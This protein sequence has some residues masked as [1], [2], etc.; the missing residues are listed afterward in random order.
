[1]EGSASHT[2]R[3][4]IVEFSVPIR[5]ESVNRTR[6]CHWSKR[7]KETKAHQTAV[8]NSWLAYIPG[9]QRQRI[10]AAARDGVK[11]TMTRVGHRQL[12]S[13]NLAGACKA[14]RDAVAHFLEIDD[15]DTKHQWAYRGEHGPEYAVVVR[16]ETE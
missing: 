5:V 10:K 1:M 16:I 13:D 9:S 4:V 14:V 11:V 3:S 12:D 15:G 2:T 6:N 8:F 7:H